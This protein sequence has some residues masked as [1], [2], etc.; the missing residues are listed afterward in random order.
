MADVRTRADSAEW[1]T[2][3]ITRNHL[4]RKV[5]A[6][7][8]RVRGD[9]GRVEWRI[10][11]DHLR[12]AVYRAVLLDR[13]GRP[14][15]RWVDHRTADAVPDEF[16]I[17]RGPPSLDGCILWWQAITFDPNG[18]GGPYT[19]TVDVAQDGAIPCSVPLS[20]T[21]KPGEGKSSFVA[22]EITFQVV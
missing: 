5:M 7:V 14:L 21:I 1:S 17:E 16:R 22:S 6:N 8:A 15:D 19:V 20:G 18:A 10:T 11:V 2:S 13:V 3:T 9:G 12:V 4:G